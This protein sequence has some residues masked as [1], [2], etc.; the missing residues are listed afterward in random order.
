MAFKTG[1]IA[2]KDKDIFI[3]K[4]KKTDLLKYSALGLI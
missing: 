2:Y 4:G 1:D 3:Y